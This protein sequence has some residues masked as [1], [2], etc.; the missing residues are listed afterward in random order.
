MAEVYLALDHHGHPV[1][2]KRLL[3]S[4]SANA[5]FK[6]MFVDEARIG[7]LLSHP[8]I[9]RVLEQGE[10]EG[11][12]Y[13]VM[14]HIEGH[15]L[16]QPPFGI[17]LH[18]DQPGSGLSLGIVVHIVSGIAAGLGYAHALRDERGHLRGIVHRDVSPSNVLVGFDGIPR[19]IDFGIAK[20]R[21]RLAQTMGD[22]VKGKFA[23]MSPEQIN[24]QPVDGRSDIFALGAVLYALLTGREAFQGENQLVTIQRVS[25]AQ[26]RPPSSLVATLP[27]EIDDIVARALARDPAERYQSAEALRRDLLALAAKHGA[28][29]G[30]MAMSAWMYQQFAEDD[31]SLGGDFEEESLS[32]A[33]RALSASAQL[34]SVQ[35]LPALI[36]GELDVEEAERTRLAQDAVAPTQEATMLAAPE[37]TVL[38]RDAAA[39]IRAKLNALA[40]ASDAPPLDEREETS[41][42][43]EEHDTFD[44]QSS[45]AGD[46]EGT[47][48]QGFVAAATEQHALEMPDEDLW[49]GDSQTRASLDVGAFVD[50]P[51]RPAQRTGALDDEDPIELLR[52]EADDELSGRIAWS[53]SVVAHESSERTVAHLEDGD[54]SARE[55][56]APAAVGEE[57]VARLS[58]ERDTAGGDKGP[59]GL[60]DFDDETVELDETATLDAVGTVGSGRAIPA[61]AYR[62]DDPRAL[63]DDEDEDLLGEV[64]DSETL[65]GGRLA[66]LLDDDDDDDDDGISTRPHHALTPADAAAAAAASGDQLA[67]AP[68][69]EAI[70]APASRGSSGLWV[71]LILL[72]GV[73]GAVAAIYLLR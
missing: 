42:F 6:A 3:A 44:G 39:K 16:M 8:N 68:P 73:A 66:S 18:P 1:A 26:V 4:H 38:D 52:R 71:A 17:G 63:A 35:P 30:A 21:D 55:P 50:E 32:E 28:R 12:L 43:A 15:D 47:H 69:T 54:F 34:A 20:A 13:L 61:Q 7:T 60:R 72:L 5:D 2:I 41:P 25:L 49:D 45:G 48:P 51:T 24:G 11:Q 57:T 67:A 19:L 14:E 36:T 53:P 33:Q 62:D 10:H 58:D 27:P 29:F 65:T 46:D 40:P 23:Y 70:R 37:H 9:A 22:V 56:S 64:R 59:A 31:S